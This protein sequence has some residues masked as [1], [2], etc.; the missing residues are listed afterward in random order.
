[1]SEEINAVI[2][3]LCERLGTTATTLI[4]ELARLR[5]AESVVMIVFGLLLLAFGVWLFPRAWKYDHREDKHWLD[6]SMYT[7]I[8]ILIIVASVITLSSWSFNLAGWLASPTAKAV[9]EIL[10]RLT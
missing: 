5:I 7:I 2:N 3:N 6:D 8:P 4:P 1:M 9:L 10:D